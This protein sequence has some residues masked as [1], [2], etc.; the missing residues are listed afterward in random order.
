MDEETSFPLDLSSETISL[1]D[2]RLFILI[3]AVCMDSLTIPNLHPCNINKIGIPK[4]WRAED[5]FGVILESDIDHLSEVS[6]NFMSDP[7]A[8]DDGFEVSR[9]QSKI[10][11]IWVR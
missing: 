3:E 2:P 1:K 8:L 11:I 9:V 4:A 7:L 5:M 10:L 6:S